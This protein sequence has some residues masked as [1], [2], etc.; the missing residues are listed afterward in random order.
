MGIIDDGFWFRVLAGLRL[1]KMGSK[2]GCD[3]GEGFTEVFFF[4]QWIGEWMIEWRWRGR[5][6]DDGVETGIDV[7]AR[8]EDDSAI[9]AC[10]DTNLMQT[11]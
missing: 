9:G 7:G 2:V 8:V 11:H 1:G 6:Q 5:R 3:G 4:G 10:S